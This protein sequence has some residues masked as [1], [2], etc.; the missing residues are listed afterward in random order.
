L[1]AAESVDNHMVRLAQNEIHFGRQI[2]LKSVIDKIEAVTGD[3][4]IDLARYLFQSQQLALTM[5]GPVSDKKSFE[6]V[7]FL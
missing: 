6:D 2:P 1:L 7:L 4:I 5:L 3:E